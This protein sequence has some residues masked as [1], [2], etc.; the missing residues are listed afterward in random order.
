MFLDDLEKLVVSSAEI[1]EE[2]VVPFSECRTDLVD[3]GL[4]SASSRI[5]PRFEAGSWRRGLNETRR[6]R[7]RR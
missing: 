5:V 2:E 4:L 3:E 7:L 6:M 1:G